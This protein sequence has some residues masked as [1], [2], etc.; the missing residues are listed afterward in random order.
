VLATCSENKKD[1]W[2]KAVSDRADKR[3][4]DMYKDYTRHAELLK[5]LRTRF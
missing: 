5:K 3:V 2:K 1:E 4:Q